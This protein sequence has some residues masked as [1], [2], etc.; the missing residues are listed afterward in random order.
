MRSLLTAGCLVALTG[1]AIIV[2]PNDG[3]FHVRSVFSADAVVGNGQL[4]REGRPV[5]NLQALDV[6][7][8]LQVDVRVGGAPSLEIEADS[9]LLPLIRSEVS[10]GTLRIWV[11]GNLRSNNNMRVSYTVPQL[12]QL[13]ANGSGRV[14]VSE[15]NG[16]PLM[17]SKNGSGTMQLSG[18]V[19]SIDAQVS[20]SGQVDAIALQTGSV[21]ATLAGS[22]RMSLG[23]VQGVALNVNVHGSGG[24]QASGAAQRVNA[25]VHG[26]G[27]VNLS[28]LSSQQADLTANGSGDI[29]ALVKDSVVAQSNGSGR[30]TV[31][32]NPA[33]RNVSGKHVQVLN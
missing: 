10:G 24:F 8:P 30:I 21:N 2:T 15:L 13:R 3:D 22:G 11:E 1:C 14:T 6:S 19:G 20:G 25:H 31:Y 29:S 4:S 18:R 17:L 23:A 27:G 5:G 28:G 32:G 7:G 12:S 9:N 33:Q 26:S 16:A